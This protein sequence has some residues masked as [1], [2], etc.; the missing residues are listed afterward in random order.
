MKSDNM[1]NQI[2]NKNQI[3]E[4]FCSC[5]RV[6]NPTKPHCI[7]CGST[8]LYAISISNI[9]DNL[10]GIS[11][12]RQR[13]LGNLKQ[14]FACRKCGARFSREDFIK[15]CTWNDIDRV[16]AMNNLKC[17]APFLQKSTLSEK[18]LLGQLKEFNKMIS[19]QT[20]MQETQLNNS[21]QEI[22]LPQEKLD[23]I[24]KAFAQKFKQ[25]SSKE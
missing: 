14:G 6:F 23:A 5:G 7:M 3:Q 4:T 17:S 19:Q 18:A 13:L 10:R 24:N 16:N 20:T 15:V 2:E 8:N 12:A 21:E 1:A 9:S 25:N 22:K 11:R